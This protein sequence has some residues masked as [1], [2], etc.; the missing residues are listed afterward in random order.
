MSGAQRSSA[1]G[2]LAPRLRGVLERSGRQNT[3]RWDA[4]K[5]WRNRRSI[6]GSKSRSATR[7]RS[8]SA[9]SRRVAVSP[10]Q[11]R[12]REIQPWPVV[13]KKR[14]PRLTRATGAKCLHEGPTCVATVTCTRRILTGSFPSMYSLE[15]GEFLWLAEQNPAYQGT[16]AQGSVGTAVEDRS[17]CARK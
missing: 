10:T 13:G 1:N 16:G 11:T 3:V 2:R 4:A 14:E 5:L 15:F 12:C 9:N 8:A 6:R 7:V 17:D